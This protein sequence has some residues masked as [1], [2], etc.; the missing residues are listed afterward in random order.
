MKFQWYPLLHFSHRLIEIF[1][2][3][4]E[5]TFTGLPVIVCGDFYQLPPVNGVPIY[6]TNPTIKDLVTLNF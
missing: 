6:S 4:S 2:C 5:K 3:D 1:G